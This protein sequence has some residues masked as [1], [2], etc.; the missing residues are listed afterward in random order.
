[1]YLLTRAAAEPQVSGITCLRVVRQA[2]F[3]RHSLQRLAKLAEA[4]PIEIHNFHFCC[5]PPKGGSRG[6]FLNT[7]VPVYEQLLTLTF[8]QKAVVH[9][10]EKKSKIL[11]ELLGC[12]FNKKGLP[13]TLG[14]SWS[15]DNVASWLH[16]KEPA[17]SI[18]AESDRKPAPSSRG[19]E[20]V[21][22]L[23]D[24]AH[25]AR[26]EDRK[27][28]KRM[29][30]TLYAKKRR[31]REKGEEKQLQEQC[32]NL[33]KANLELEQENLRFEQMLLDAKSK[34][35]LVEYGMQI[36]EKK[37]SLKRKQESASSAPQL[38]ERPKKSKKTKI[39][40]SPSIAD[41]KADSQCLAHGNP[42]NVVVVDPSHRLQ[43]S[44]PPDSDKPSV[45]S[46]ADAS[47][48]GSKILELLTKLQTE[49]QQAKLTRLRD[50]LLLQLVSSMRGTQEQQR[51]NDRQSLLQQLAEAMSCPNPQQA[52]TAFFF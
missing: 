12:G 8:G 24:A 45:T 49:Q 23:A 27:A 30:D 17:N 46:P 10:A 29:M 9:V 15:F 41:N 37:H 35:S 7:F 5:L 16:Q 31:V 44:T 47:T 38:V 18:T 11:A 6:N 20:G 26:L 36:A 19:G 14:G 48:A 32:A 39:G 33:T 34:I 52:S 21:R 40:A 43:V 1:M 50:E 13:N 28:P 25:Q 51:V 2:D 42:P 22:S 4:M 3:D